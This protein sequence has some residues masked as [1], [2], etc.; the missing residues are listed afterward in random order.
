MSDATRVPVSIAAHVVAAGIAKSKGH[1]TIALTPVYDQ[2]GKYDLATWPTSVKAIVAPGVRLGVL[3]LADGVSWRN[4]DFT[5]PVSLDLE[6]VSAYEDWTPY[7]KRVMGGDGAFAALKMALDPNFTSRVRDPLDAAMRDPEDRTGVP[8]NEKTPDLHG[9]GRG[10]TVTEHSFE[11]ARH[12]AASLAS[13]KIETRPRALA[14]NS[15]TRRAMLRQSEAKFRAGRSSPAPTLARIAAA[16]ADQ[17]AWKAL[18]PSR[19]RADA[20]AVARRAYQDRNNTAADAIKALTQAHTHLLRRTPAQSALGAGANSQGIDVS[21]AVAAYQ[22]ASRTD[23]TSPP[24]DAADIEFARRK[25]F[26][27][28]TNPSLARLFC[29]VVDYRCDAKDLVAVAAGAQAYPDGSVLDLDTDELDRAD[30][31]KQAVV[32]E[33]NA[34]F[35]LLRLPIEGT[36]TAVWSAAKLRMSKKPGAHD[37]GEAKHF[38]P[39][40]REEIDARVAGYSFADFRAL[41]IAEQIDGLV[42]LGQ[43]WKTSDGD[44]EPRYDIVTLDPIAAIASYDNATRIAGENALTLFEHGDK[45]PV[46]AKSALQDSQ[47]PTQRGGG[48]ALTDRWRQAHAIYRH[49]D[50]RA[51]RDGFTKSDIVLDASDLTVGYKL[52]VGVRQKGDSAPRNRW[53]TLMQRFVRY[54]PTAGADQ[55]AP[56]NLDSRITGLYPS[57]QSRQEADDG[58]LQVA[59]ALRD[60]TLGNADLAFANDTPTWVTAFTEEIIGAWRGDPM[61]LAC[62]AETHRLGGKD[63]L[64]DMSYSLPSR[65]DA[66]TPPKLRF[67]WRYHFGLRA[68]FVGG[69]DMPLTRAIGHYET[70]VGGDLVL[71]AANLEGRAFLR[72]ERIDAATATIPDWLYGTLSSATYH[73]KVALT[74][75]FPAPQALRLMVR[76]FA[77]RGNRSIADVPDDPGAQEKVPGVGFDRRVLV[78]P[79]VSL[80]FATAHG[81]FDGKPRSYFEFDVKM[82]D[83]RVLRKPRDDNDPDT[84]ALDGEQEVIEFA[85]NPMPKQNPV[86]KQVS[87]AWRPHVVKSRPRGGLRSIDH[88]AAWGGFPVYRTSL[89]SGGV[90]PVV[91]QPVQPR[92]ALTTDQGEILLRLKYKGPTIFSGDNERR[93]E[94]T[95]AAAGVLPGSLGQFEQSGAAVF[96]PLPWERQSEV[97][98]QPYYPDPAVTQMVIEVTVS[99]KISS[100]AVPLYADPDP[101]GPTPAGYPDIRPIVLDLVRGDAKTQRITTK[102]NVE[103]RGLPHTPAGTPAFSLRVEHVTV[104]LA[105]GETARIRYWC[106]PSETFLTYMWAGTESLIALAVSIGSGGYA[107]PGSDLAASFAAGLHT[108]TGL[109]IRT[110][111]PATASSKAPG[112]FTTLGSLPIPGPELRRELAKFI[113]ATMLQQ[114]IPE[115]AAISEIAAVHAVDLPQQEP[116]I[117]SGRPWALLRATSKEIPA[118]LMQD[119][120]Q[121]DVLWDSHNW[122]LENQMPGAIDVLVDGSLT[123]HGPS[124]GAIE[125]RARGAAAARGRFDDADRGRSRDDRS[126]GLWPRPDNQTYMSPRRLFGFSPAIDGTVTLEREVVTL[127]RIEGFSE[128]DP[129]DLLPLQRKAQ[130]AQPDNPLRVARPLSFPD[131]CARY[132]ELYAVA[133]SR[134]ASALRTRYEELPESLTVPDLTT[135]GGP[136]KT[137]EP[138][139]LKQF[140]LAATVRPTRV[141]CL[142]PLPSFQWADSTPIPVTA[143]LPEVYVTRSM[144]ARVRLKRP[145]FSSG[146]G[147]RLGI[148][149]WPP[150]LFGKNVGDVS[151]DVV[152]PPPDDRSEIYLRSLPDDG[153]AIHELQDTDLGPGGAWVTRWGADPI[154][155]LGAARGWLLSKDNFPRVATT[156]ANFDQVPT[157]PLPEAQLVE[158]VLMPVPVDAD[159]PPLTEA[160]PPGGFMAVSLITYAPRFDAE[161]EL[162]YVDLNISPCTAVYPFVRLGMVRFQPNAPRALQV[163][164]PVVEWVQI[165]PERRLSGT[166]TVRFDNKK[167]QVVVAANVTGALSEPGPANP[168]P[169]TSPEQ[170]PQMHFSLL[171][172]RPAQ[173]NEP[174]DSE[175]VRL[176]PIVQGPQCASGCMSW[177]ASFELPKAEYEAADSHW[178][179]FVEEVDR[180][181]PSSYDDEPRYATRQDTA[182]V[183]SGPRFCARLSLDNLIVK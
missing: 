168:S 54:S 166:A 11:R 133:V 9:T 112:R 172:R 32:L 120:P 5:K 25:L 180:F 142:T 62:G 73:T 14:E 125:I 111:A 149:I 117:V 58:Q 57:E 90:E 35:L 63:L 83:P 102:S 137:K 31:G 164:E 128:M 126:R 77:D 131:A 23:G 55:G 18:E 33:H 179:V 87:I 108:L 61:G 176:G 105:A 163:S 43:R 17:D 161:Q 41:A 52:D 96:R 82:C 110:S 104:A 157:D 99:G 75:R 48:L 72:N 134:H 144:R 16:F 171:R 93:R 47:N 181:R 114:P 140:W 132:I 70:S 50:S 119:Q 39:C 146:E 27:I 123:V 65:T 115:I 26:A 127:L 29:F 151:N 38:L 8:T 103:C 165:M 160:K 135:L 69:I 44:F 78:P 100:V 129:I 158:N 84:Y 64:I 89:S 153:T 121:G 159:A 56:P 118:I 51:Q 86:W 79:P 150:N 71:P 10:T 122:T 107:A 154:R 116:V 74:G 145:W 20:T 138:K 6:R 46:V 98:R 170:A 53:H 81:A 21:E 28:Q 141:S 60:W 4:V 162:W 22:L 15:L 169:S 2:S 45:L 97:E 178:S 143:K 7:W 67:G 66:L 49:L 106:V 3:P 95:W 155:E 42:D 124:T 148:V 136:D 113:R 183:D 92:P 130:A 177:S 12:T 13:K 85:P 68:V 139:P 40:T 24:L 173:D 167:A 156:R 174:S 1:I 182:F 88:R 109:S 34:H 91:D 94:I 152:K 59:T 36:A 76:S 37:L 19:K 175:V 80:D 30:V 147:E 101:T